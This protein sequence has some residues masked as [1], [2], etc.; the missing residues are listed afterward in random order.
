M[1]ASPK[2]SVAS[3][4]PIVFIEELKRQWMSTI[5]AL[6]DP[7]MM[8]HP[9]YTIYKANLAMAKVAKL[10]IKDIIGK[11]CYEV[12][13]NRT[14]PCTN[15]KMKLSS[16]TKKPL[17]YELS[18]IRDNQFFEVSSQ[19]LMNNSGEVDG[20]VQVYRDRTEARKLREQ[21]FQSEKLSSIGLLAGGI[22]HE[23][24]NPLGGAMIFSEMLLKQ[25]DPKTP[26]YQDALEIKKA[27]ERCKNIVSGLLDFARAN[28]MKK[29]QKLTKMK[30]T[31]AVA[32]AVKFAQMAQDGKQYHID[33]Q[34]ISE[35]PFVLADKNKLIQVFLN[36]IQNA[37]QA[38]DQG[39]SLKLKNKIT[40]DNKTSW[41][42]TEI[43]DTGPGIAKKQQGKIFDPFFTTK[44][45]GEGTGLGLAVVYGIMKELNGTIEFESELGEGSTFKVSLP[46][47]ST[48]E[49]NT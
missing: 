17:Q 43:E 37:F 46:I 10:D 28:P 30:A 27:T 29:N 49:E 26:E 23:L 21:L 19:P 45:P 35:E 38:M 2:K 16:I 18:H 41:L 44:E 9:N 1:S 5:D 48:Q 22:A 6:V 13:A 20:I 25:L 15:C 47:E 40:Q 24:N 31:D 7:L 11:K 32:D 8:V 42:V 36:L 14:S 12:F 3:E 39:G 34:W 4:D 33:Y